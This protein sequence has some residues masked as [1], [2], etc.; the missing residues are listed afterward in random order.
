MLAETTANTGFGFVLPLSL[1]GFPR[2]DEFYGGLS[3]RSRSPD[4]F[5]IQ[6]ERFRSRILDAVG[7]RYLP[8]YRMADGEF[9]FMVGQKLLTH[10]TASRLRNSV[11]RL[12]LML[13]G[14][15]HRTCWGEEYSKSEL[16][17]ARIRFLDGLREVMQNGILAAYFAVRGDSWGESYF[18]PVCDWLVANGL[19]FDDENYAPFYF[20]YALLNDPRRAE[21]YGARR[22]L[23]VT[24]LTDHRKAALERGLSAEGAASVT[25]MDISA[26]KSMLD[27]I[28]TSALRG[29]VDIA[30]VGAGIGSVNILA[31]LRPLSIPCIDCGMS[32][33][34]LIDG[35]RRTE[36]PFLLANDRR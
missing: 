10:D 13:H 20:V 16:A 25:F 5:A 2:A 26:N 1:P 27:V 4:P 14:G 18:G 24:H 36:R 6:Y 31:Q 15:S 11:Y 34:C 3:F 32:L 33:E 7:Q 23:V 35:T 19:C 30:L 12:R 28:D 21:L 9:S 8:I 22:I 29:A 17:L